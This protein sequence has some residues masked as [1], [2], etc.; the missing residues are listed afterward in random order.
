MREDPQ[1]S[2]ILL[3][4]KLCSRFVD[5]T[6]HRD[7]IRVLRLG[8]KLGEDTDVVERSLSVGVAHSTVQPADCIRT[9]P[10]RV[11]PAV[12]T[13]RDSVEVKV[14]SNA[15]LARPFDTLEEVPRK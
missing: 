6:K 3:A 13:S 4:S 5:N 11:I 14:N 12:L 7:D 8:S 1:R 2:Q 15:V 10:A 9:K